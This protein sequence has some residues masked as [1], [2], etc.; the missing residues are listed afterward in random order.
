MSNLELKALSKYL[1][2]IAPGDVPEPEELPDLLARCWNALMIADWQGMKPD[3]LERME[4]VSWNPPILS[5]DIERHGG[6]VKGSVSAEVQRWSINVER[7]TASCTT[8]RG[9]VV[10]KR[11]PRLAIE[12]LVDRVVQRIEGREDDEWLRW[13]SDSRVRVLIGNIILNDGPQQTVAGRRKRFGKCLGQALKQRG[14][15]KV[16]GTSPHTYQRV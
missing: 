4:Q 15:G 12:P 1:D 6:I 10:G 11:A 2:K 3:K 8:R 13:L 7:Q 16:S 14:W 5:F 9:R